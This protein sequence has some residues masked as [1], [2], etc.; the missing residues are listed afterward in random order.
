MRTFTYQ[1]IFLHYGDLADLN[2]LFNIVSKIK[3]DE[4]YNLGAQ[5]HVVIH[6]KFLSTLPR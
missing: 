6:L 2:S 1:K 5:S 4:I 3:P